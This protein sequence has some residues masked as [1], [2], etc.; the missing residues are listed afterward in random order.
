MANVPIQSDEKNILR[1][2]HRAVGSKTMEQRYI[3]VQDYITDIQ[4]QMVH[5][6]N[7]LAL[8]KNI[9]NGIAD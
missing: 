3:M 1:Y 5:L 9:L 6:K 4:E 7:A 8:D 2:C